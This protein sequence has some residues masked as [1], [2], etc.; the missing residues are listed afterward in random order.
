MAPGAAAPLQETE[1]RARAAS[2][3]P[4]AGEF[5]G[6]VSRLARDHSAALAQAARREGLGP[7]DALDAAQEAFY[8]FLVLPQARALIALDG[9]A[10]GLLLVM[11]RN[12]ARN[13]RRRHHRA[14]PH[15]DLDEASALAAGEPSADELIARAEEHVRFRGCVGRLA[16]LQ[17][18]VVTLRM[19]DQLSG[20]ETARALGLEPG[21]VAVLLHRARKDLLACLTA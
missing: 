7:E 2:A 19:I 15:A 10:R 18:K 11:V 6:W 4:P 8:T 20:L 21:R 5:L 14:V 17:R 13:M 12:V 9:E 16:A 1:A 3:A